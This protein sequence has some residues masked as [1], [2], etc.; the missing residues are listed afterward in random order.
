MLLTDRG[1]FPSESVSADAIK[2]A[3]CASL[4]RWGLLERVAATNAPPMTE[5]TFDVGALV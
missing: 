4:Q 5:W 1:S 2:V 3:G